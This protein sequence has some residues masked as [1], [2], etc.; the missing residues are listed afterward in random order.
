MEL[1]VHRI[2]SVFVT[3]FMALGVLAVATADF[4]QNKSDSIFP[5]HKFEPL[6]GKV[7]G[8]LAAGVQPVLQTEGRSGPADALGF[9]ANNCS[10]R[11][12]YVSVQKNPT[13]GNLDVTVGSEGKMKQFRNLSIATLENVKPLGITAPYTL[14]EV[15]VNS[16]L[17]SPAGDSF[18]ATGLKVLDGTKEFPLNVAK[19]VSEL[20]QRY[21]TYLRKHDEGIS[22]KINEARKEALKGLKASGPREKTELLFLTWLSKTERLQVQFRTQISDGDYKYGRG[23]DLKR[24]DGASPDAKSPADKGPRFGTT[25]GIELGV[26]YEVDRTGKSVSSS[27]SPMRTFQHEI[28]PPPQGPGGPVPRPSK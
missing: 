4:D 28:P 6:G 21:A 26:T 19:V 12:V 15:E 24:K 8:V 16:G 5:K 20:Q 2:G 11:W 14:V 7:I 13:I 22:V 17:G 23:V 10:Y 9:S 1:R 3:M 27:E 18:V 25:F